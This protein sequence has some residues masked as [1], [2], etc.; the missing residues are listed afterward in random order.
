[1]IKG[2]RNVMKH[3]PRNSK[4][5]IIA[6]QDWKNIFIY[7]I[8]ITLTVIAAFIYCNYYLKL[9]AQVCNNVIFLGLAVVQIFH[10]FNLIPPGVSFFKN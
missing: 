7:S 1:M 4:E 8:V 9:N 3:P 2:D 6:N 10:V 5:N